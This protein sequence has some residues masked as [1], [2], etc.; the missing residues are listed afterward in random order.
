[1]NDRYGVMKDEVCSTLPKKR[2]FS[3]DGGV[4]FD[5]IRQPPGIEG[6][7]KRQEQDKVKGKSE[8]LK[9]VVLKDL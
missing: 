2:L 6:A 3:D 4:F 9:E 5:P 1:M 7:E 8:R